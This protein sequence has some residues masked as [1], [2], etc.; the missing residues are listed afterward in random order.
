MGGGREGGRSGRI[1]AAQNE[2][3][4]SH[5][6]L[7]QKTTRASCAESIVVTSMV[8]IAVQSETGKAI[9]LTVKA[10]VASA[11]SALTDAPSLGSALVDQGPTITKVTKA[12]RAVDLFRF[13][14][15]KTGTPQVW[16]RPGSMAIIR[17][18]FEALPQFASVGSI[19]Y[20]LV[21]IALVVFKL[22]WY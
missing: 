4:H 13:D 8:L 16:F 6:G 5:F 10:S 7:G 21:S 3:F 2:Q 9:N 17:D 12:W 22:A 1:K 20:L 19:C 15:L 18:K 14:L 11:I